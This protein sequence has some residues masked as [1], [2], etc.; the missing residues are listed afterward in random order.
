LSKRIL[1]F[2]SPVRAKRSDQRRANQG[3]SISR[4]HLSESRMERLRAWLLKSHRVCGAVN[5]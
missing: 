4:R 5:A 1:A 3:D 2:W